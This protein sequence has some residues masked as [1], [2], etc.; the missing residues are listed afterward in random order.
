MIRKRTKIGI[1]GTGVGLRT[2]LPA[3]R[4]M[5]DVD[6][7]ALA[8]SSQSRAIDYARENGIQRGLSYEE[9]CSLPEID[10]VCV[11][12]PNLHHRAHVQAALEA[13]KH[14]LCEKPLAMSVQETTELIELSSAHPSQ[15]ALVNH[16]LRF[17]P[18]LR[19]VK[20]LVSEGA[21]GR[22]YFVKIHQQSTG[23]SDR[24]APWIWSFDA[25][26]GGGVRLAMGSHL[27]D[28]VKFWFGRKVE[29]VTGSMDPVVLER[30]SSDGR[31]SKVKASGFFS[32]YLELQDGISVHLSA[33]AASFSAPRF[34]FSIFGDCGELHF[35]LA[36]K[37]SGAV[38]KRRE[39]KVIAP[40]YS[41]SEAERENKIS[42]FSGSFPY[43]ANVIVRS[44][45]TGDF[46]AL[47]VAAS[48]RDALETQAILD[49]LKVSAN[50]GVMER[51]SGNL[52]SADLV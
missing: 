16:Q 25:D 9:L 50:T 51:L 6:V 20:Q 27:V 40:K 30:I 43:F 11:A 4:Q 45:R 8:G 5:E 18:Y 31:R 3:F 26:E 36:G 37:L 24:S 32:S 39:L 33:T 42:I 29:T 22:P 23:F 47:D 41:V 19:T 14:V 35:D 46:G 34:D 52:H 7:V 15:L 49:A 17:N 12:S 44:I 1:I 48:F 10:L 21:I 38:L 13:G 2:H 28:L